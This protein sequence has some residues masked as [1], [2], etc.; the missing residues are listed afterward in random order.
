M[1]RNYGSFR[2][3]REET[4]V[5]IRRSKCFECD[6]GL[7][8]GKERGI[9]VLFA[10][11]SGWVTV[12][13]G[14]DNF[15]LTEN[16]L[17]IKPVDSELSIAM[18]EGERATVLSVEFEGV[19]FSDKA[20]FGMPIPLG[21]TKRRYVGEFI[22]E[23]T[24]DETDSAELIYESGAKE[25]L[26][27]ERMILENSL[28]SL[29]VRITRDIMGDTER[30]SGEDFEIR[31]QAQALRRYLYEN[32][33]TRITLDSLCFIFRSNKTTICKQFREEYGMTVL[34]YL[35]SL[36]IKEAK[37]LIL[38]EHRSVTEIAEML[39]FESI[40]Y[41]TRFF[42]KKTGQTP[43]EYGRIIGQRMRIIDNE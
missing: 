24:R 10:V 36:R 2:Q 42:K 13:C 29:L 37:R 43:T 18:R 20:I 33:R 40:H 39:G 9:L 21:K 31:N 35:G 12:E 19:G 16:N 28:G 15:V 23:M 7:R 5:S 3:M 22:R 32:Y 14:G 30:D 8:F 41:F 6:G 11:L 27:G 26:F 1:I 4:R 25:M 34:G 38:E 17:V